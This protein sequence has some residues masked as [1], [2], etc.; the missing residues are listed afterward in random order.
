[1]ELVHRNEAEIVGAGLQDVE[2]VGPELILD[3]F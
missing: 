2:F 1:M 3:G